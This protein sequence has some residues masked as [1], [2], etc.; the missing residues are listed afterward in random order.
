MPCSVLPLLKSFQLGTTDAGN[1]SVDSAGNISVD[2]AGNLSVD[3]F[4]RLVIK[5]SNSMIKDT[6]L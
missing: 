3:S 5:F 4:K 1:I 2:S 6:L